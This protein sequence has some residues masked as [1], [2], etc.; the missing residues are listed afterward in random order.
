MLNNSSVIFPDNLPSD[1][2]AN[3]GEGS[4]VAKIKPIEI[5]G[6]E[7]GINKEIEKNSLIGKFRLVDGNIYRIINE[8]VV[9]AADLLKLAEQIEPDNGNANS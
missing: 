2:S 9:P 8:P 5:K 4:F 1:T 3:Q 7:I 6:D